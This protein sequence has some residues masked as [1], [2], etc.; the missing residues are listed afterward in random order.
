M[1]I[2]FNLGGLP[3]TTVSWVP[4]PKVGFLLE[5]EETL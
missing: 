3:G 5:P 4:D 1:Q 2:V